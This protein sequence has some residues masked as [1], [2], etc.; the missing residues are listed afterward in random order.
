L[1]SEKEDL[2]RLQVL[3]Q[4]ND[5]F[6]LSEY[7]LKMRG[8]GDFL[9]VE[10][11]GYFKFKYLNIVEDYPVLLEAQKNVTELLQRKDFYTNPQFKYLV[12]VITPAPLV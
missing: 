2:E 6:I 4:T 3:S 1:I 5:G 9:G 12:K 10:Q 7:D 8:P 11:S